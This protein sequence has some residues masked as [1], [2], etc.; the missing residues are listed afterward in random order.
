MVSPGTHLAK[1]CES[2]LKK[3]EMSLILKML[4]PL[5]NQTCTGNLKNYSKTL[6]Y[7]ILKLKYRGYFKAEQRLKEMCIVKQQP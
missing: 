4:W 2:Q 1:N 3:K 6:Y 7:S 5:C